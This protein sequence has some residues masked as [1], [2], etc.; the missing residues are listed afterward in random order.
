[1]LFPNV[2]RAIYKKNPLEEVI[3][4]LRF[5]PI[6][7][8]ESDLPAEFQEAIRDIFPD[9]SE[10][11]E[12][13]FD[14]PAPVVESV[15]PEV[16]K[17]FI[18]I[19]PVK[20]YDFSSD[21][22]KWKVSLTRSFLALTTTAYLKWE[23]FRE[24]LQRPLEALTRIYNPHQF[25]RIGLRYIDVIDKAKFG[26]DHLP[27]NRLL[28][29]QISSLLTD[30]E[31]AVS[32]EKMES[33]YELLFDKER[34]PDYKARIRAS[35]VRNAKTLELCFKIDSDYFTQKKRKVQDAVPVLNDFKEESW[36]FFRWCISDELH[37]SMEPEALP[38]QN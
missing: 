20:R 11:S 35:L 22:G 28:K 37:Q 15:P 6:L 14:I 8:I 12:L 5:P 2:P 19:P 27:W 34:N 23:A 7:K 26:L 25:T 31:I 30:S 10:V 4:Q 21:D 16:L 17:Q 1:M 36:N 13:K 18:N 9:F 29:T 38:G 3:C 32:I 24:K 33:A